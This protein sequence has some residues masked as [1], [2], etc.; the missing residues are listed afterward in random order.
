[1]V[2]KDA[3]AGVHAVGFTVVLGDPVSVELGYSVRAAWVERSGLGLRHLAYLPKHLAAGGLIETGF[4]IDDAHGI[5]HPGYSQ[6][7]E[8]S[9]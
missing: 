6:R 4:G 3:V 1:M 2:E 9:R 8:F 7:S 5:Q